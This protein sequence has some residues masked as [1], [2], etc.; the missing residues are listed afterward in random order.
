VGIIPEYRGYGYGRQLLSGLISVLVAE[1]QTY[2]ELDVETK[3]NNAL[4][5]YLSRGFQEANAYDYF[6]L[7]IL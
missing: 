5:L 7:P 6:Q 4:S 1:G 2:F 3:N